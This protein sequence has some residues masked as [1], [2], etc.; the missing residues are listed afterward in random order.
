[1]ALDLPKLYLARHGDGGRAVFLLRS[2][3]RECARLR[4]RQS[5]STDYSFVELR[6]STLGI[7]FSQR[8]QLCNLE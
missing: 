4:A 1:M 3:Q 6:R 8:S 2:C 5:R 7:M